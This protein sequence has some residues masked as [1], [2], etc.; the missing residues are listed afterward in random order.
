MENKVISYSCNDINTCLKTRNTKLLGDIIT[1]IIDNNAINLITHNLLGYFIGIFI[2]G[3]HGNI[4]G[5]TNILN[6]LILNCDFNLNKILEILFQ[7]ANFILNRNSKNIFDGCVSI[8]TETIIVLRNLD[9]TYDLLRKF[10]NVGFYVIDI[11]RFGLEYNKEFYDTLFGIEIPKYYLTRFKH[12]DLEEILAINK[13]YE[14]GLTNYPNIITPISGYY[15]Q[16]L[17]EVNPEY[18]TKISKKLFSK[19]IFNS[20]KSTYDFNTL[21]TVYYFRER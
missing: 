8:V 16:A 5:D 15:L 2:Q 3:C 11:E 13:L 18:A 12:R 19:F 17:Y 4:F 14:E 10:A 20:N 9:V 1:Y 7:G 6:F 21:D